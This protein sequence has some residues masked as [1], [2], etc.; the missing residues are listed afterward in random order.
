MAWGLA[1]G[2]VGNRYFSMAEDDEFH[3]DSRARKADGDGSYRRKGIMSV[4]RGPRSSLH[5]ELACSTCVLYSLGLSVDTNQPD[6]WV[7]QT[8]IVG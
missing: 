2:L 8:S 7:R 4:P 5:D 1:L 3:E 6:F